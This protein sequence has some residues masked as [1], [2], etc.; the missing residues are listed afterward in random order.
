MIELSMKNNIILKCLILK[1]FI[2]DIS[3]FEYYVFVIT[4]R[5]H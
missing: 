1:Y 2:S 5:Y 3:L 4:L